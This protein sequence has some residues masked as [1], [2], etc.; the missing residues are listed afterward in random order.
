GGHMKLIRDRLDDQQEYGEIERVEG[1]AQ[2]SGPPGIPLVLSRL[3]PPRD[4]FYTFNCRHS[5]PLPVPKPVPSGT[6][7]LVETD[8]PKM[9]D[10]IGRWWD[11]CFSLATKFERNQLR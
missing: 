7:R 8:I 11:S 5:S 6:L 1:P 9:L 3:P 2:P 4:A 10:V